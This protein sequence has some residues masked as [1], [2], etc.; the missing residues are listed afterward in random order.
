MQALPNIGCCDFGLTTCD[1]THLYGR[2]MEFYIPMD[3]KIRVFPRDVSCES[4]APNSKVGL[5]WKAVYGFVGF[6]G[7]G[8]PE[9]LE[10]M[11]EKGLT[12]GALSLQCASY[13]SVSEP[14]TGQALLLTDFGKWILSSFATVEEVKAALP[15]VRVWGKQV[16]A[17]QKV[18]G[19]HFA[20]HDAN[21]KSIAIEFIDGVPKVYDNKATVL[22]NDPQLPEQWQNLSRFNNLSPKSA[23]PS[24]LNGLEIPSYIEGSGMFGLPGDWSSPSRFARLFKM[25]EYQVPPA[26]AEEGL[27]AALH[28][29]NNVDRTLGTTVVQLGERTFFE[30]TRYVTVKDS[31]N[32][33]IYY[34][35]ER[36]L[37]ISCV[38]LD[39]IDFGPDAK[40]QEWAILQQ[41]QRVVDMTSMLTSASK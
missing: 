20:I 3:T 38:R 13:Q 24:T 18:P 23:P 8:I 1:G 21:G 28:I 32:K 10:G 27:N 14:E 6:D 36:D 17:V 4:E 33:V 12:F 16:E 7:L 40:R 9:P 34:R 31:T 26:D 37:S 30:T 19:L 2:S 41:K 25:L 5:T 29:L 35:T 22:T 15:R 39:K 11:N